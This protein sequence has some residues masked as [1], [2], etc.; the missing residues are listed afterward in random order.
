MLKL[1]RY[2]LTTIAVITVFLL[3]ENK[4][5]AEEHVSSKGTSTITFG[6]EKTPK[7]NVFSGYLNL[8]EKETTIEVEEKNETIHIINEESYELVVNL[9]KIIPIDIVEET[10]IFSIFDENGN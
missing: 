3:G 7:E 5:L 10:G 8:S 9:D 6:I 4:M 2:L 1:S